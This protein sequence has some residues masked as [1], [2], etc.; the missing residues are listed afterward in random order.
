M[1]SQRQIQD[2][3]ESTQED[4]IENGTAQQELADGTK[5]A[6][7]ASPS[8]KSATAESPDDATAVQQLDSLSKAFQG[9]LSAIDPDT[10]LETIDTFQ[11][12]SMPKLP[13]VRS[14]AGTICYI[15]LKTKVFRKLLPNLK[16]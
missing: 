12:L 13:Q 16:N 3:S 6:K 9:D 8:A 4:S 15:N 11:S 7:K 10:A 1:A 5:A 14:I 2:K